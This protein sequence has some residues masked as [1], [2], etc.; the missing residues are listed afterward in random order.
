MRIGVV[1]SGE[2]IQPR[3]FRGYYSVN[4]RVDCVA[5]TSVMPEN[6]ERVAELVDFFQ[7][8]H[9]KDPEEMFT[10]AGID[11]VIIE[12]GTR[13]SVQRIELIE[14]A[15]SAGVH[16]LSPT[17]PASL[18]DGVRLAAVAEKHDRI[19]MT[20]A[21]L[22][23]GACFQEMLPIIGGSAFGMIQDMRFLL[24]IG[25]FAGWRAF[26]FSNAA[27][28]HF[29]LAFALVRR[30]IETS[31]LPEEIAILA[32]RN[33]AP[34][35]TSIAQ[36]PDGELLTFCLTS[37]RQWSNDSYHTVEITGSASHIWSDLRTW[38]CYSDTNT[39]RIG[40]ADDEMSG[41]IYG[42]AGQ[43]QEFC[44]AIEEAREPEAGGLRNLLPALWFRNLLQ[45]GIE[46]GQVHF[47]IGTLR[48][49]LREQ[50]KQLDAELAVDPDNK[51]YRLE[52]A[53]THAESGEFD[54]AISEYCKML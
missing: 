28:C 27:N 15:L 31:A 18:A 17:P 13:A 1:Y 53:L 49:T 34:N 36:F 52:K 54:E 19:F 37:N 6:S 9:Y 32:S 50:I 22:M 47:K 7:C 29:Q 8:D 3:I 30:F 12:S 46:N 2:R 39:F 40:G 10:A 44:S 45:E 35:I 48:Q 25:R 20:G 33:G 43:L 38:R 5:D 16:V 23:F 14:S 41:K 51:E 11:G 42:S 21:R 26:L 4:R 24:G